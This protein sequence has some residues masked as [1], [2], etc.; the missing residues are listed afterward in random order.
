MEKITIV[1]S[2]SLEGILSL[3]FIRFDIYRLHL[4]IE[5]LQLYILQL[6]I[7]SRRNTTCKIYLKCDKRD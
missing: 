3:N 4:Y 6:C 5:V 2:D 1:D 7:D